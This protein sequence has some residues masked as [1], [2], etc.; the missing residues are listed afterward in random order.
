MTLIMTAYF[1]GRHALNYWL[2]VIYIFY[3]DYD[4]LKVILYNYNNNIK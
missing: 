3:D 2:S 1:E 4:D